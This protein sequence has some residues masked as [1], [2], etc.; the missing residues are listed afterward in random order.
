MGFNEQTGVDLTKD[1]IGDKSVFKVK[2]G[3]APC[4]PQADI[5]NNMGPGKRHPCGVTCNYNGKEIPMEVYHSKKGSM[6][7]ELLVKILTR[8]DQLEVFERSDDLPPP[9]FLVD[10]HG[11]RFGLDFLSYINNTDQHG[12]PLPP[13][14]NHHWNAYIGLPNATALWQV[15]DS[16][17]Q[18]GQYKEQLRLAGEAIND[19][20]R[21]CNETP[22]L[23]RYDI[24]PMV[25]AAFPH[26]F[27]HV[28]NNKKALAKRGW[29]PM[30]TNSLLEPMILRKS[31]VPRTESDHELDEIAPGV[32]T[33]RVTPRAVPVTPGGE[34][35]RRLG[36]HDFDHLTRSER[37]I[38]ETPEAVHELNISNRAANDVISDI[39]RSRKRDLAQEREHHIR[40]ETERLHRAENSSQL[41]FTKKITAGSEAKR[42]NFTLNCKDL[43]S[44]LRAKEI[45]KVEKDLVLIM[46]AHRKALTIFRMAAKIKLKPYK[47]WTSYDHAHMITYKQFGKEKIKGG[48]PTLKSKRIALWNTVKDS[49]DPVAPTITPDGYDEWVQA[50]ELE[51]EQAKERKR[52]G[53]AGDD[54]E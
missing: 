41:D 5:E 51:E 46:A 22:A 28:S 53:I 24:V 39:L 42:G 44:A 25:M 7:S 6:S 20:Q 54:V 9:G 10:G 38:M 8:L 16:S 15:G 43:C 21:R 52:A 34:P 33:R 48:I 49:P 26:S 13:T 50:K 12:G 3:E 11:S 17:E 40:R 45:V 30:N 18:N 27:G 2:D 29:N 23:K 14:V 4:I 37:L 36:L 47:N 1:W 31:I 35:V 19:T 32:L